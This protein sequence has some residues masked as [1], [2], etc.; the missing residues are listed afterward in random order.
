MGHLPGLAVRDRAPHHSHV[1]RPNRSLLLPHGGNLPGS[2]P[3]RVAS[4]AQ[5]LLKVLQI[6]EAA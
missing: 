4:F 3:V 5:A 1:S 2:K 6:A